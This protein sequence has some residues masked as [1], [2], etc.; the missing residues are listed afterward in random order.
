MCCLLVRV[1]G[2]QREVDDVNASH[3]VDDGHALPR[4]IL[5]LDLVKF[6]RPSLF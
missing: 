6:N 3:T 4:S 5:R 1:P 2:T